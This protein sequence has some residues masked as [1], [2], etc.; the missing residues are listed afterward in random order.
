M[1]ASDN[2]EQMIRELEDELASYRKNLRT[3]I[4][5][6]LT[7]LETEIVQ[8]IRRKAG[9]HVRTGGLLNSISGSK[10][11]YEDNGTVVGEIGPEGIPYAAIHEFGGT[12][13]PKNKQFLAIP[14]EENRRADGLPK[15]TTTELRNTGHSFVRNNLI[16]LQEGKKITPMFILKRSVNI[17][18]RPYLS[19]ALAEKQDEIL[20]QFGV[21][22]QASFAPRGGTE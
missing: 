18:A 13:V 10:K 1:E 14:T 19:T 6:A 9:L 5:R 12:V 22:L 7:L 2:S 15:M 3:Q 17:P 21:F 8:Q 11:V 16:F 20:E 4:F